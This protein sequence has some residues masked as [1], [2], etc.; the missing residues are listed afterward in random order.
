MRKLGNKFFLFFAFVLLFISFA[1][2]EYIDKSEVLRIDNKDH[3]ECIEKV[4]MHSNDALELYWNCRVDLI[5]SYIENVKTSSEFSTDYKK[6]LQFIKKIILYRR[7]EALDK[8]YQERYNKRYVQTVFLDDKD[9]YYFD[10]I[11]EKFSTEIIYVQQLRE[12]KSRKQKIEEDKQKDKLQRES[13]CYKYKNNLK[14]YNK[15]LESLRLSA[16]C[17]DTLEESVLEKELEY[18]FECK[19]AA[20]EKYPDTL[21]LYNREYER[22]NNIK[23]DEY[24]V[25]REND[26]KIDNRKKELNK[27]ISGPKLSKIQILNLRK[28]EEKNC[29]ADKSRDLN[30]FRGVLIDQCE[31]VK[32]DI[33][34]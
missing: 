26:K 18:K 20:N 27:V 28:T 15:C 19:K 24:V 5:N 3:E 4:N 34:Q 31:K 6:E 33:E 16:V 22:L 23:K 17:L 29:F 11:N 2:A 12:S 9:W 30:V 13:V 14:L 7:E 10:L 8:V 1:R 32:E 25:D 21:V